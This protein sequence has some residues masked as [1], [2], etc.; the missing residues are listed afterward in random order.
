V[1]NALWWAADVLGRD[2]PLVSAL[3]HDAVLDLLAAHG[4]LERCAGCACRTGG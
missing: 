3:P 1:L 4:R 2:G